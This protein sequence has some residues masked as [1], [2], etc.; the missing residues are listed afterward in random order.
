MNITKVLTDNS[1]SNSEKIVLMYL[2]EVNKGNSVTLSGNYVSKQIGM[3]RATFIKAIKGLVDKGLIE[4]I[5]NI[6]MYEANI[7][8]TYNLKTKKYM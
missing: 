6:N 1:L 4:K 8:N 3:T 2:Y 7:A 5:S